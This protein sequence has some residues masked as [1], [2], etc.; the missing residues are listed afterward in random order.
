MRFFGKIPLH[1][2]DISNPG[3]HNQREFA[4][5]EL[6][7]EGP[8]GAAILPGGRMLGGGGWEGRGRPCSTTADCFQCL[9][10]AVLRRRRRTMLHCPPPPVTARQKTSKILFAG[11]PRAVQKDWNC[12]QLH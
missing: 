10:I 9:P 5:R 2:T 4:T 6:R 1:I 8:R 7:T 11:D 12:E 3:L